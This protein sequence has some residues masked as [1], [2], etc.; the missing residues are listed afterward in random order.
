MARVVLGVGGGIAAY[1]AC[2][3]LRRLT[4]S[5]HNVRV[6]PSD[7]ALAFVG[8]ATWAA[9]SGQPVSTSVW[10]DVHEVP[11][12]QI[13]RDADLVLVA[14]ATANRMAEAAAGLAPDLLGNV[15]L[16]ATCPVV[17]VPAM[18]TEM[19]E[20]PATQANVATLRERGAMVVQPAS[21]RLTGADSG[22]GRFPEAAE[23]AALAEA[24]LVSGV[25][26]MDLVGRKVVVT[27]GGTREYLDPVRFLGNRSSGKQGYAMAQAARD[28][29][30]DVVLI[31]ANSALPDPAAMEIVR[32]STAQ[33]M[34]DLTN[35]YAVD[36]DVV[37]M[38]A[39][40]ADFRPDTHSEAKIKKSAG[41]PTI[42]LTTN[43]DILAGL[44]Q[45]RTG[46]KPL[47]VGFAAETG[48]ASATALQHA[49][50]KF[51]RKGADI[52]VANV[53]GD[54]VAFEVDT[55]AATVL[56]AGDDDVDIA[57]TTKRQLADMVWDLVSLKMGT[58]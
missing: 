24:V 37:V 58:A 23:V 15:L 44:A 22:P 36:A 46:E 41:T 7:S 29:G 6:V 26:P 8:A 40:V 14:P 25:P 45:R 30:A 50:R 1:K 17:Y 57:P 52:M 20:N 39:A 54:G 31:S 19:W 9:L 16:T 53:V 32:V 33:E 55:N 38:A 12:V 11:H 2:E 35:K 43:P 4:E 28:R 48:D 42:T 47:L 18:H 13:G 49:R 56:R 34:A 51:A 5:G 10:D 3:L 27:A 21:G